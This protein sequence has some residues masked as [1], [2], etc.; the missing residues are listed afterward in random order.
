M[1][2]RPS[3]TVA[4]LFTD[5]ERST[6]LWEA[7]PV[8]MARRV[9]DHD[10]IIVTCVDRHA[11]RVISSQGDS[12]AAAFREAADAIAAAVD[13]QLALRGVL[14]VRMAVHGGPVDT[15]NGGYYGPTLNRCG[16]LR[17]A[18][19]GGQIVCSQAVVD[20][21]AEL[22][23]GVEVVDLGEHRLRDLACPLHIHQIDHPDLRSEFPPL[24]T[25]TVEK[26]NLP[27]QV[28]TFV[29]RLQELAEI[30]KLLRSARLVTL[31]G[32][33]GCGKSRLAMETAAGLVDEYADGVWLVELASVA[34]DLTAAAVA[35]VLGVQEQRDTALTDGLVAHMTGAQLLLVLDNC[36]H[37]LDSLTPVVHAVI[38]GTSGV[39][40]LAT[41]REPVHTYGEVTYPVQPLPLP[42]SDADTETVAR[43]DAVRLFVERSTA[44][45]PD[46][47]LTADSAQVVAS[48]CRHLDGI[49]LAIE[50]AATTTR[51]LPVEE[52][53]SR[54]DDRFRL[55]GGTSR[56]PL[57]HHRTLEATIDWSYEQLTSEHQTL[58]ARLAVFEGGWTLDAAERVCSGPPIDERVV[59]PLLTDLVD[60]SLVARVEGGRPARHRLLESINAYAVARGQITTELRHK[61]ASWCVEF[62]ERVRPWITTDRTG[63]AMVAFRAEMPNI[64]SALGYYAEVGDA[65]GYCTLLAAVRRFLFINRNYAEAD[66]YFDHAVRSLTDD[67]PPGLRG[68]ILMGAG[69]NMSRA[70][71]LH[72]EAA[73]A[74]IHRAVALLDVAGDDRHLSEAYS[75]LTVV[76]QEPI[77]AELALEAA[78]RSGD[79]TATG[80]PHH[81]LG[82]T[83]FLSGDYE[84][85]IEHFR[86]ALESLADAHLRAFATVWLAMTLARTGRCEE[87][88][89]LANNALVASEKL[90][91]GGGLERTL[92]AMGE[93]ALV[94]DRP[95]LALAVMRRRIDTKA[96]YETDPGAYAAAAHAAAQVGDTDTTLGHL[97]VVAAVQ[98]SDFM[99]DDNLDH[100]FLAVAQIALLHDDGDTAAQA[101]A[102]QR[103][104]RSSHNVLP[105]QPREQLTERLVRRTRELLAPDDFCAAWERGGGLSI[106]EVI[107]LAVERYG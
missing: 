22:P 26:T 17:D 31:T 4:F 16:R 98:G 27:I 87:A 41:S 2:E 60:K 12:F 59:L 84:E 72:A 20:L 69:W 52:I 83:T 35:S 50:L 9:A 14:A 51:F 101:L 32:A 64:R 5:I 94:S 39:R 66:R 13:A 103:T 86:L 70:H 68:E 40:I 1:N 24:N 37:V 71:G 44:V 104:Y 102:A 99:L 93:I 88:L 73:G 49:P 34:P 91:D 61:H 55:L 3:G 58:L 81:Y 67:L 100:A 57:A 45:S 95:D 19:H 43:A 75:Y 56:D 7:D 77:Y 10:E 25:L 54:L 80:R 63:E 96:T 79:P 107:A 97:E 30:D 48:I 53:A 76:E 28:T 42:E 82:I 18:A 74:L 6:R 29:G 38:T 90:A 106:E 15:R 33:G 105:N 92:Q 47:H 36:E 23:R 46:F 62:A 65:L 85:A 11:G 89:E 8:D 78:Q 21:T